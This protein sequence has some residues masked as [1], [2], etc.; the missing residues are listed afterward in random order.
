MACQSHPKINKEKSKK[1]GS[2]PQFKFAESFL[3]PPAAT[4][5]ENYLRR[6]QHCDQ[7]NGS[8]PSYWERAI[9]TYRGI[10]LRPERVL[11]KPINPWK[12]G[13]RDCIQSDQ[14][15]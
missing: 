15:Q 10:Q 14:N 9:I 3:V 5:F 12:P 11:V 2:D 1:C 4:Q 13:I 7:K 6:K 8:D